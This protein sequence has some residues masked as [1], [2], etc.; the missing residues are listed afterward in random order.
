[1]TGYCFGSKQ[2]SYL[3]FCLLVTG[4]GFFRNT[5]GD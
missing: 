5:A 1:M 4:V 2:V 3:M